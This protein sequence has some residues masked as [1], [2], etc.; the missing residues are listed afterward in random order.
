MKNTFKNKIIYLSHFSPDAVN[1]YTPVPV[2]FAC[3][4]DNPKPHCLLKELKV[5]R[6]EADKDYL[7]AH[8]ELEAFVEFAL[9]VNTELL[10]A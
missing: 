2:I 5:E 10:F 4:D 8:P 9:Q 6:T 3:K 7:E 1:L